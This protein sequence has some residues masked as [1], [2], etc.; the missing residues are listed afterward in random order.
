VIRGKKQKWSRAW[1]G[2]RSWSRSGAWAWSRSGAGAWSWSRPR[3]RSGAG[4]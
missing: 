2:A 3:S 4:K 1:A